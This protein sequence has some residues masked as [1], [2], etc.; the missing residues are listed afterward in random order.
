MGNDS[1]FARELGATPLLVFPYYSGT[2]LYQHIMHFYVTRYKFGMM[3]L[4]SLSFSRCVNVVGRGQVVLNL[5]SQKIP[6]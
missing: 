2:V 1:I 3:V 5:P 4:L 6:W